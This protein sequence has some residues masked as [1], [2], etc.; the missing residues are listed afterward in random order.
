M[1]AVVKHGI[2]DGGY[3][4]VDAPEPQCGDDDVIVE[5]KAAGICGSDMRHFGKDSDS[6][7]YNHIRG[8]EFTGVISQVG[9]NVTEWKVGQRVVTDNSGH[10]CGRCP[11]CEVADFLLCPERIGRG[12]GLG[13]DG[14]FTKYARIPGDLLKVHKHALWEIPDEITFEEGTLLDPVANAYKAIAQRS[15]LM[16][17]QDVVIFG[18]GPI[19]LCALQ[20]AKL[21][22]AVNIVMVGINE[23]MGIRA[24]LAKGLGA[25]HVI[26]GSTENVPA[27]AQEICGRD[28][29]GLAVDCSG[30]KVI[31][32]QAIELLRA[33]GEIV[34]VGLNTSPI[35]YPID[36]ISRKGLK[37]IGHYA[38]DAVSWRHSIRLLQHGM[39]DVKSLIT[40]RLPLSQWEEGFRLMAN[41]TAIKVILY[42]DGD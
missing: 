13:L 34:R 25:T 9:K 24:E 32:K 17:G 1:K 35:D 28:N 27:R 5:V 23:D 22:G 15:S 2:A 3:R 7:D 41:K 19:G 4:Y 12:I 14:G 39:V 11:A 10:A 29:L 21:M 40:H 16:P 36:D 6:W 42:Y 30:A 18:M 20:I 8:H 37:L 31:L 26:N 38:Y 33:N